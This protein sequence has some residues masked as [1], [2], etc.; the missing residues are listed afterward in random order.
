MWIHSCIVASV[1][2]SVVVGEVLWDNGALDSSDYPTLYMSQLDNVYPFQA[3]VA[4]DFLISG[5]DDAYNR[6]CI[7][8]VTWYGAWG[9]PHEPPPDPSEFRF[10]VYRD[11]GGYPSGFGLD[12]PSTAAEE[13]RT[14]S[15][16]DVVES[17]V[18]DWVDQYTVDL[19]GQPLVLDLSRTYWLAIQSVNEFPPKWYW[20]A[21]GGEQCGRFGVQGFP[22]IDLPYWTPIDNDLAFVLHGALLPM[23]DLTGDGCVD[24]ADLGALLSAYDLNGDGDLDGDGDTDQ[25]DLGLLL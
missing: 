14:V 25:T 2:S 10:L 4:D 6:A 22:L 1:F 7:T 23:A 9:S 11:L 12:D 17:P 24:Q 3:Q 16:D 15:R 18:N 20:S 5:S 8:A 13:I 21:T 19:S